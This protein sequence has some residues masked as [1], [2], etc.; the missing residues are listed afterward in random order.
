M[1]ND[2]FQKVLVLSIEGSA[3]GLI[4]FLIL[5]LIGKTIPSKIKYF[6]FI[7][8]F[9]KLV[10]PFNFKSI[11]SIFNF[12]NTSKIIS[13][14]RNFGEA[15]FFSGLK[16]SNASQNLANT[17]QNTINLFSILSFI[18]ILGIIIFAAYILMF[19]YNLKIK[20]Y[21]CQLDLNDH[22]IYEIAESCFDMLS[23]SKKTEL[24]FS[25]AIK[26]P[27]V[28]G[29]GDPI[30]VLPYNLPEI[31]TKDELKQVIMHEATHIKLKHNI[32][33]HII[34]II[35]IVY[36][37][38]PLIWIFAKLTQKEAE[39]YCDFEVTKKYGKEDKSSYTSALL[40]MAAYEN[41]NLAALSFGEKNLKTRVLSIL[42]N[43][44]F[45]K[46]AIFVSICII[47]ILSLSFLTSALQ[48][49]SLKVSSN[50]EN[51]TE[52]N[53]SNSLNIQADK[54]R[55][56][57][58]IPGV[59]ISAGEDGAKINVDNFNSLTQLDNYF[60]SNYFNSNNFDYSEASENSNAFKLTKDIF[61][62]SF[63]YNSF[64]KPLEYSAVLNTTNANINDIFINAASIFLSFEKSD[65]K[66][67][68][69]ILS[70]E[71][72]AEFLKYAFSIN[73]NANKVTLKAEPKDSIKKSYKYKD[74]NKLLI[75]QIPEKDINNLE[76]NLSFSSGSIFEI[77][78]K[79]LNI[80]S[81]YCNLYEYNNKLEN[82]NINTSFSKI[83]TEDDV[84]KKFEVN[85]SFTDLS[86]T[87]KETN[88]F[89]LINSM[90]NSAISFENVPDNCN[91]NNSMGNL[92]LNLNNPNDFSLS[93]T[94][95]LDQLN[96]PNDW[97][98]QSHDK[99]NYEFSKGSK[100][101]NINITT[102]SGNVKVLSK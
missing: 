26:S 44:R 15:I 29:F 39:F 53:T 71:N 49:N 85:S 67:I 93:I 65:D 35:N 28:F 31:M 50:N 87:I 59:T 72:Q 8:V 62:K 48:E 73:E 91:I 77:S 95:N 18:W 96:M 25:S 4:I 17:T 97:K 27:F 3:L 58:N 86:N 54:D 82:L 78:S 66:F 56:N 19:Y 2:V 43:K 38:N 88:D 80:N 99:N 12:F 46:S 70:T 94:G 55:V 51:T 68:H 16:I 42:K 76:L 33:K 84:L 79:N 90:G 75:V 23:I 11:F 98:N 74:N 92:L 89:I 37:F 47:S 100:K 36:W 6:M 5:K 13:N 32:I 40:S 64:K 22:E 83:S 61:D 63:D 69:F 30:I 45:S 41:N 20:V 21:K 10:L 52:N 57:I 60:D 102:Q 9:V 14:G 1:V 24:V 7:L 34:T 101:N 81:A